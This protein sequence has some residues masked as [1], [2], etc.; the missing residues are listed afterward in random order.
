MFTNQSCLAAAGLAWSFVHE[1]HSMP[2][3]PYLPPSNGE[4][5]IGA[6]RFRFGLIPATLLFFLAFLMTAYGAM[7]VPNIL[8]DAS[9]GYDVRYLVNASTFPASLFG[10]AVC[11]VIAGWHLVLGKFRNA[12]ML[13]LPAFACVLVLCRIVSILVR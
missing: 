5:A 12:I 1:V 2:T 10:I 7:I 8:R 3:T 4:P 9:N 13:T 11:C 6:R